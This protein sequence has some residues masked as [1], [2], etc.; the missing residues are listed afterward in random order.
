MTYTQTHPWLTFEI[1]MKPAPQKLW[2][3]LGECQSKCY[4]IAG[5]PLP[6][7]IAQE[8]YNV[9]LAKGALATTA[10]EG[11]TLSEEDVRKHLEGK[12]ELPPSREYQRQE[13]DNIIV[14]CNRLLGE[15]KSGKT[16]EL[17]WKTIEEMNRAVLQK[18]PLQDGVIAGKIRSGTVTVG[19]Y[20]APPAD[21]CKNL[22]DR[23]CNWLNS[24]TFEYEPG[25]EV[26]FAILK[27]IVAHVYLAWIHPF[28]DG[29][30][31]T[32]RLVE[33][34]ILIGSGMPA[35]SCQLL[36]NHYNQTR[37]EYYRQLDK[38]SKSGGNVIPFIEY[39]VQGFTEGLRSQIEMIRQKQME[40]VWENY[41]HEQFK[42]KDSEGHKRRHDLVLDL[43]LQG[44]PIPWGKVKEITPRLAK[45]YAKLTDRTL[46]RD[47]EELQ[48][49]RLILFADQRVS[50]NKELVSA[51]LPT[52][53]IV[54]QPGE[55]SKKN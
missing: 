34:Q 22:L 27:A 19:R 52:K 9:Y 35:L 30:G 5:T 38:A 12:L 40:L 36:S 25:N 15:I 46:L 23:L 11:N 21:Q 2:I 28:G 29:N 31:R 49:M 42:G 13:V 51:F 18:T 47:L 44:E 32:A 10:I 55:S 53:A 26:V 33:F 20:L 16:L 24:K 14:E 45:L 39:A 3:M 41:V 50:A 7:E 48:E 4:H 6:K 43:S 37:T 8:L 54:P 1:N 17:S